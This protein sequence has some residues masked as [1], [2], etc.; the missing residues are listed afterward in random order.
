MMRPC[1]KTG[2][3]PRR[4]VAVV[5]FACALPLLLILLLGLWEVG[6]LL[7]VKQILANAAR[8][9]GRQAATGIKSTA[10][11]QQYV[12]MSVKRA[13]LDITNMPD[14]VVT[15]LT[16]ASRNDPRT[17][18]QLD[19]FL[20]HVSMPTASFRWVLFQYTAASLDAEATWVSLAD[21][22]LG[23]ATEVIPD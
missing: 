2:R 9:G 23:D 18:N 7:Q 4:G 17:A 1:I 20:I 21:I 10:E 12:R 22:P 13:G 16:S 19:R 3:A 5:E 14:P 15:N 11:I 8:E 6:R